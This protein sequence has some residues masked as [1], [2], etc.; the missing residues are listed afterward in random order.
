MEVKRFR[1][2]HVKRWK[3][4]RTKSVVASV[5]CDKIIVTFSKG[6]QECMS[7]VSN[8][9][10]MCIMCGDMYVHVLV[11]TRPTV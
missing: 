1:E 2:E 3:T 10:Y 5:A 8:S 11:P 6:M 7:P 4:T 9:T